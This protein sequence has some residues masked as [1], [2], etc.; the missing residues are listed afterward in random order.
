VHHRGRDF[1]RIALRIGANIEDPTL[2]AAPEIPAAEVPAG[3][4]EQQTVIGLCPGGGFGETQRW[5]LERW[6]EAAKLVTAAGARVHWVI[7][8]SAAETETGAQ[9][10]TLLGP[11]CTDLTGK[12][13]LEAFVA[14]L[15]RCRAVVT[16][17]SGP[18]QLAVL[19]GVPSIAIFGPTE[20][21]LTG[22]QGGPH[23]VIRRHV[24]CSPCFLAKCPLDHR[25][26][27]EIPAQRVADAILSHL[28][29]PAA[30]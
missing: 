2:T 14:A 7:F 16:H 28:H 30:P 12:T 1:L 11:G 6:A 19:L 3:I 17:D 29:V 8:G 4:P 15:L 25:C 24:E 18:L 27:L 22:P 13:G 20:S 5:P 10:A 26:M 23:T 9:L 21:A